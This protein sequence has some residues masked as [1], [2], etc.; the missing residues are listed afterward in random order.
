MRRSLIWI[1]FVWI[2][3]VL[4]S[5]MGFYFLSYRP[6]M[7]LWAEEYHPSNAYQRGRELKKEGRFEEA[8]AAF[9][10]GRDY[11]EQLAKQTSLRRH[12]EQFEQGLL[13]MAAV[14]NE[15]GD[16]E[17]MEQA[18]GL[19][20]QAAEIDPRYAEGQPLL[21]K[22][23]I[24]QKLNR[25]SE[26]VS[27]YTS[28]VEK[29]SAPIGV[30]AALGR[31]ACLLEQGDAVSAG[32]DWRHYLRYKSNLSLDILESLSALPPASSTD[33][34]YVHARVATGKGDRDNAARYWQDYLANQPDDR[35]AAFYYRQLQDKA[36]DLKE[37]AIPLRDFYPPMNEAPFPFLSTLVDL[38][39]DRETR[40]E[41][42][43]ELSLAKKNSPPTEIRLKRDNQLLSSL[44]VHS[45]DP[46]VY[47]VNLILNPGMN[48]IGLQVA[49]NEQLSSVTLMNLHSFTLRSLSR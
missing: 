26:A 13:E 1:L 32:R 28:A 46:S 23:Q 42:E 35:S 7:M 11:F 10:V 48:P 20:G 18:I 29:G 19:Y 25:Y 24:L 38:Y 22:G 16:R 49:Q 31:G 6:N 8:L 9:R 14:Y 37:E 17:A 33:A 3:A 43:I 40:V 45:S 2:L 44:T 39:A 41:L 12:R 21:A 30:E 47:K 5:G 27:A 34:L 36:S 15:R 4:G